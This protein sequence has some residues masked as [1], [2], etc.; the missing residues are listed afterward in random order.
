MLASFN[1]NA[2]TNVII[3]VYGLLLELQSG[4][5]LNSVQRTG[6]FAGVELEFRLSGTAAD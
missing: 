4:L 1:K 3:I 6:L 2:G 5:K